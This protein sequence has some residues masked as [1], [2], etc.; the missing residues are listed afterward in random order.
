[1]RLLTGRLPTEPEPRAASLAW[2][3]LEITVLTGLGVGLG[4]AAAGLG[5]VGRSAGHALAAASVQGGFLAAGW[6]LGLDGA[7][8]WRLPALRGA[9][10]LLLASLAARLGAAGACAYLLVPL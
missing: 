4:L 9:T 3:L 10:A 8:S 1:M 6:V 7:R 2:P 5:P